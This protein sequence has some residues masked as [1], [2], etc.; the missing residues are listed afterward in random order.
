MA[1]KYH[2]KKSANG[3]FMFNLKAA[4][5]EVILT[6]ET[7]TTKSA[8]LDGIASVRKNAPA[9]ANYDRKTATNGQPYFTLLAAN[10]Q[11]LGRSETYS[12][13]S[14]M[15]NGIASVK[16]NGPIAELDDQTGAS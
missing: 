8:A 2:L 16:R 7:Y 4:N 15:E 11:T 5:G 13:A 1:A 6:G 10:K 3:Q 12:A 9:D 14:A